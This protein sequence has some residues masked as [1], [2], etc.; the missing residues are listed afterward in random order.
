MRKTKFINKID[1]CILRLSH[2]DSKKNLQTCQDCSKA[3]GR[4]V[5]SMVPS[6]QSTDSIIRDYAIARLKTM[7]AS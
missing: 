1:L 3:P 6:R 7:P 2:Q 5:P 4:L